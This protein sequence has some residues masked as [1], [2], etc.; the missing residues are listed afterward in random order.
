MNSQHTFESPQ[1]GTGSGRLGEDI[2]CEWFRSRGIPVIARNLRRRWTGEIDLLIRHRG[3]LHLI[4]V[5]CGRTDLSDLAMRVDER[6]LQRMM[7]TLASF[8]AEYELEGQALQV[9]LFLVQ[10]GAGEPRV[11]WVRDVMPPEFLLDDELPDVW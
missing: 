11:R 2:A 10:L 9:D 6:K 5:K 1:P 7:K 4:E 8:Y 3:R